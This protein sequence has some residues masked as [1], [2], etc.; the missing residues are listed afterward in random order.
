[1]SE[2]PTIVVTGTEDVLINNVTYI[3]ELDQDLCIF[4]DF[5]L[6]SFTVTATALAMGGAGN[7]G[8]NAN[9]G[10]TFTSGHRGGH[11]LVLKNMVY[12]LGTV[13]ILGGI[14]GS[15]GGG[16]VGAI[17]EAVGGQG[18]YGGGGG[19]CSVAWNS[20]TSGIPGGGPT[21]YLFNGENWNG[22]PNE[23]VRQGIAKNI[24]DIG[25]C[26]C[27]GGGGAFGGGGGG[28]Y[29]SGTGYNK[30]PIGGAGSTYSN[31]DSNPYKYTIGGDG[32][33]IPYDSN[34]GSNGNDG[35]D[36]GGGGGGSYGAAG[37][38]GGAGGGAGGSFGGGGGCGGGLGDPG[39]NVPGGY[40]A[41]G[42]PVTAGGN[43]GYSIYCI[44]P[45]Y[46]TNFTNAQSAGNAIGPIYIGCEIGSAGTGGL[47]IQNYYVNITG[48]NMQPSTSNNNNTFG[49]LYYT[50][51]ASNDYLITIQN[52]HIGTVVSN[53]YYETSL[54]C[55]NV[56]VGP[57]IVVDGMVNGRL[58][59]IDG[60][61]SWELIFDGT[62]YNL[63]F[64]Q[65]PSDIN[66]PIITDYLVDNE[67]YSNI[68]LGSIFK[69]D[70]LA[71]GTITTDYTFINSAGETQDLGQ[72]F[73]R[74][75]PGI[76]TGY[77]LSDGTDLGSI[78]AL[79]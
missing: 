3:G 41:P 52:F 23:G 62:S 7:G 61:Y 12:P 9:Y 30:D 79:A 1:M 76:K 69:V 28:L 40:I 55:Y 32:G 53:P 20:Q 49:Q 57:N 16:G 77:E 22:T 71:S 42:R 56:L 43:G 5:A 15:G 4:E 13:N 75:N 38:G 54:V 6:G 18:A 44:G 24:P 45:S 59:G 50:G 36:H 26:G 27:G 19:G 73:F 35:Y 39:Y 10:E 37:G 58:A 34:G 14:Q 60:N 68:D 72:V 47:T 66:K 70:P 2:V 64:T 51:Y 31:V 11:C 33:K 74:G 17:Y 29:T 25:K 46:I 63:I 65:S 8:V 21:Y 78:F 48:V 67:T